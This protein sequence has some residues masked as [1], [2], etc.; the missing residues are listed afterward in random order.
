M[1][2]LRATPAPKRREPTGLGDG[3]SPRRRLLPM[4][5]QQA[6]LDSRQDGKSCPSVAAY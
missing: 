2:R 3:E 1:E 5:R 6:G 4:E